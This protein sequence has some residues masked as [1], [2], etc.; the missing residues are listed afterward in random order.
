MSGKGCEVAEPDSVA[1]KVGLPL[2]ATL[3][4][5]KQR[6][7]RHYLEWCV[8]GPVLEASTAVAAMAQEERGQ[9]AVLRGLLD[10]ASGPRGIALPMAVVDRA[11]TWVDLIV[12]AALFDSAITYVLA[13]VAGI[14]PVL[15]RRAGK[16][17]QEEQFHQMFADR[18]FVLL[19]R[20]LAVGPLLRQQAARV[21]VQVQQWLDQIDTLLQQHSPGLAAESTVAVWGRHIDALF[22]EASST[23][24]TRG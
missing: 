1:E 4:A 23:A 12:L 5:A 20:D 2:V 10:Q 14:W 6:L 17:L 22:A 24:D 19:G 11:A 8:R 15:S 9:A 7:A 13:T 3:V 18:W 16:I 21:R